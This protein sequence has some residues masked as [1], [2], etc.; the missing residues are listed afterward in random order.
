MIISLLYTTARPQLIND[1]IARWLD[2][3]CDTEQL[4]MIVV[5]DAPFEMKN[6][7]SVKFLIN[8]GKRN[9]VTG[10]N[11]AATQAT[12]DIFVQVSDDLF[13]P[14]QWDRKILDIIQKFI[15]Q[16][17]DIVLNLLD[18]KERLD[19]N[20]HP[21]LTRAAYEKLGYLYPP[22]FESMYCDNWFQLYHSK[23]SLYYV[24][25][26][27]FW[28]HVHASTHKIASDNITLI[29]ESAERYRN[30]YH[31]LLKYIILHKLYPTSPMGNPFYSTGFSWV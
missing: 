2:S 20:H 3:A 7:H 21:V 11:M 28:T 31:T 10:W 16:R 19:R 14:D 8:T 6:V 17:P 26:E 12:G 29:H 25:S 15:K 9:C 1:V 30:G 22:D 13:P 4:E 24:S 18:D 23:Y 5:T 27:K